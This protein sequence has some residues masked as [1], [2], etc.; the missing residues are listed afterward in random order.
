MADLVRDLRYAWR[1]IRKAPVLSIATVVT[2]ALGIGLNA[3]VFTVISGLMLRP[4]VTADV[5]KFVHLQPV[6]SGSRE[7]LHESPECTTGDYIA[8][9]DRATTLRALAAWIP[10]AIRVGKNEPV[11]DV[12]ML[13]SCNFFDVYGLDRVE[14]GR[15]F[16]AEE[17][18]QPG[19]PV[20]VISDELWRRRFN[21][22]PDI[23]A[24]PLILNGDPYTIVGVTPPGFPG[25][26]RGLGV[27][28]PYTLD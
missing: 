24:T 11:R 14:L 27:W 13:V 23:L 2:L 12:T 22:D 16:H 25:R 3:G 20:A 28:L 21:A 19:V 9:R 17:C 5:A 7:P 26:M 8:L 1:L 6:Y 4:R 15:T 18:A 10:R